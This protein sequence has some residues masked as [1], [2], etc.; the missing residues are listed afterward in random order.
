MQHGNNAATR[1]KGRWGMGIKALNEGQIAQLD[2]L[3]KER[4]DNKEILDIFKST[5]NMEISN[6]LVTRT[7]NRL[8]GSASSAVGKPKRKYTKRAAKQES[9]A[10][11]GV[12]SVVK[13]ITTILEQIHSGYK[14][15]FL[16]LRKQLIESRNLVWRMKRNAGFATEEEKEAIEEEQ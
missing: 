1:G 3:I 9:I 12:D 5:Y 10:G 11:G 7:R 4:K 2:Q 6:C 13:E 15:I 14:D 8:M 16:H